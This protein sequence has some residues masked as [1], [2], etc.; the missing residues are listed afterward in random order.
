MNEGGFFG[1]FKNAFR[2]KKPGKPVFSAAH[3][4]YLRRQK[5]YKLTVLGLQ[6]LV[7]LV[8]V[9]L[10]ELL[11]RLQ[12]V[13]SFFVSSPSKM[14]AVFMTVLTG[15]H[16]IFFHMGVTLAECLAGFFIA[17]AA[18]AMFAAFLWWF[19]SVR[20]VLEPYVVVLNSLPKIA[21][22]P[23][24]IIWLGLGYKPII[25]MTVLICVVVTVISVLSGL[26]A[27]DPDKIN[28]FRFQA[29]FSH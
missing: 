17:T 24:L 25:A 4:K 13:D 11:T 28:L 16:N 5:G 18:G 26:C 7:F 1:R 15:E 10:W 2:G 6:I 23:L 21:L 20:K 19:E 12:I 29:I 3:K 8:F 9:G 27:A 22:G 14:F